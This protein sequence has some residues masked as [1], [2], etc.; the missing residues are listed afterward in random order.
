MET[1]REIK[2]NIFTEVKIFY[3]QFLV[4]LSFIFKSSRS[5]AFFKIGAVK[6]FAMLWVKK[7]FQLVLS[8]EY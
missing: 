6:N 1:N 4:F 5:Q 2:T 7:R 8:C 3:E